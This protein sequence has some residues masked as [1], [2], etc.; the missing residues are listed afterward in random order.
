[1]FRHIELVACLH[2]ST[3]GHALIYTRVDTHFFR[4]SKQANQ[5]TLQW[6]QMDNR[7][8]CIAD[9][10]NI[11]RY[12]PRYEFYDSINNAPMSQ[13]QLERMIL[14]VQAMGGLHNGKAAS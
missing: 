9:A 12:S 11:T 4:I 8:Q 3:L 2:S 10:R 5:P 13:I 1:M 7:E 14:R 6:V